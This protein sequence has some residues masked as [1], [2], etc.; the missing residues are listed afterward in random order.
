MEQKRVH[1]I[2]SAAPA[3][4]ILGALAVRMEAQF[5]S[6]VS[7]PVQEGH[8][9]QQLAN[10]IEKLKRLD[11]TILK[12]EAQYTQMQVNARYF[13]SKGVWQ[14][15]GN[16]IVSNWTTPNTFGETATWNP[17]VLFGTGA[18]AAWQNATIALQRNRYL[19]GL[20]VG[21]S[22]DLSYLAAV[23]TFDG[24]GPT[25]LQTLGNARLHQTQMAGAIARLQAAAAD[26]SDGMNS[27]VQQLNLLT[28]GTVQHL[29]MQQTTNN[30]VT[31]LLEQQTLSNKLQRDAIVDHMNF[32]NQVDQYMV[33]QGPS[34]GGAAQ[35]IS[36]YRSR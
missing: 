20:P 2:K 7:D 19:A 28:A 35:S 21:S 18:P 29:Q 23:E 34:W 5:A 27:E 8:S 10:D 32:L 17:A 12:L 16:Q 1:F 14:G 4:F 26:G 22:R 33:S 15:I 9:W 31:S 11:S 30:V 36:N 24:A 13:T 3:L 6:I 25:A